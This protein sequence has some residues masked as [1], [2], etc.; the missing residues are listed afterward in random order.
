MIANTSNLL[1]HL[2]TNHPALH[3][4]VKAGTEGKDKQ[5]AD[6]ATPGPSMSSQ[7]MLQESMGMRVAYERKGAKWKE[8]TNAVTI[9]IAKDSLPI[10]AVE[11]SGFKWLMRT[12]HTAFPL[13]L[14]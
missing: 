8:L 5:P 14:L 1:A 2:L 9:F 6:K 7:P 10:F 13:L 11:K 4:L 3:S 12:F